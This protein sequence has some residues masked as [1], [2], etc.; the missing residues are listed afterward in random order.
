MCPSQ[1]F[2]MV[3]ENRYPKDLKTYLRCN[4][5]LLST[6]ACRKILHH[7]FLYLNYPYYQIL[8]KRGWEQHDCQHHSKSIY[9]DNSL[10]RYKLGEITVSA[11]QIQYLSISAVQ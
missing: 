2:S 8:Q 11:A 9:L 10:R 5:S 7:S 4:Q 6:E 3:F 1:L